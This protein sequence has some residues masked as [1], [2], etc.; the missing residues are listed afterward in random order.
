MIIVVIVGVSRV[1]ERLSFIERL[2][3]VIVNRVFRLSC[4]IVYRAVIGYRTK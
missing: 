4:V 1:I 3:C 2:S